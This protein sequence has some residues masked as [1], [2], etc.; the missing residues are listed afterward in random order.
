MLAE[1]LSAAFLSLVTLVG[2]PGNL[3]VFLTICLNRK[4]R[5]VHYVL[6]A[7]LALCDFLYLVQLVLPQCISRWAGE[8]LFGMP[9]CYGSAFVGRMTYFVTVLHLWA[10]SYDRYKAIVKD[11]LTYNGNVTAGP[12][13]LAA[14]VFLWCLPAIIS[15]AMFASWNLEYN[16]QLF[17]CETE[18]GIDTGN[19]A[20]A[21]ALIAIFFLISPFIAISRLNFAVLKVAR[22]QAKQPTTGQLQDASA[23]ERRTLKKRLKENKAA[24]DAVLIVGT[25]LLSFLFAWIQAVYRGIAGRNAL[26]S[27]VVI[28]AK[29]LA[30]SSSMWNPIIYSVRKREF[31]KAVVKLFRKSSEAESQV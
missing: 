22:A 5:L 26:P 12:K 29:C 4:F 20:V 31:R 18:V 11:P 6:L 30:H 21:S 27:A 16:D 19:K 15:T 14:A 23:E 13:V 3:L 1:L 24:I 17:T 8:W 9:W 7:S 2:L 28:A 10:V 25:F